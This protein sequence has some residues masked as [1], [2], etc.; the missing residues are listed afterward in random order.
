MVKGDLVFYK[1]RTYK[2]LMTDGLYL[3]IKDVKNGQTE[4]VTVNNVMK[5]NRR[6]EE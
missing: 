1:Q 5:L 6:A 4:W 2:V 3:L